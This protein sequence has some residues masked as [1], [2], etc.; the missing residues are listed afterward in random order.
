ME[1]C[2]TSVQ[3]YPSFLMARW[4]AM[5]AHSVFTPASVMLVLFSLRNKCWGECKLPIHTHSSS[6]SV[7]A[8]R[9]RSARAVQLA[10]VMPLLE[11]KLMARDARMT[12]WEREKGVVIL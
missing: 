8:V 3:P 2:N 10:S 4:A 11:D 6:S 1:A 5:A 12:K 7:G 9:S